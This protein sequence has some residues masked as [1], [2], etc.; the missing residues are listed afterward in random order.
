MIEKEAE[1][2]QQEEVKAKGSVRGKVS[3]AHDPL[4]SH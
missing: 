4:D 2:K 1:V 3:F